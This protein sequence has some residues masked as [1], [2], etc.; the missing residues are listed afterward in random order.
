VESLLASPHTTT[1][2]TFLRHIIK[3]YKGFRV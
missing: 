1:R 2:R 3:V